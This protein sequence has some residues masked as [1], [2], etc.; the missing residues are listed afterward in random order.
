[1]ATEAEDSSS[2]SEESRIA[3]S[4]STESAGPVAAEPDLG[5]ETSEKERTLLASLVP[6][7]YFHLGDK[8]LQDFGRMSRGIENPE[9]LVAS[10]I[11]KG[12]VSQR[13]H[14]GNTSWQGTAKRRSLVGQDGTPLG[15]LQQRVPQ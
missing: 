13:L 15:G 1:M 14:T 12:N 6:E 11:R 9:K 10:V 4:G 7:H 3:S 5:S 2:M 8:L